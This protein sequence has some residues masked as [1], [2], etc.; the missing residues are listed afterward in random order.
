MDAL[1]PLIE[2]ALLKEQ[3][4][5]KDRERSGKYSPSYFGRCFRLQYWNRLNEPETDPADM[6]GLITMKEGTQAH[7]NL[8]FCISPE[9]KEVRIETD[10]CL[11]FADWVQE[12]CVNDFKTTEDWK[13]KKYQN[14]PTK[15][16]IESNKEYYLQ[17]G[18]YAMT[19]KKPKCAIVGAVKGSLSEKCRVFHYL[20]LESIV[21]YI[22]SEIGAL[23]N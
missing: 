20:N 9:H 12:D 2:D 21:G 3:E 11:G 7:H 17:V 23:Q 1:T 4:K 13:F 22:Q 6:K 5:R 19:L 16:F 18:W 10:D 14:I 8:Q 15:K